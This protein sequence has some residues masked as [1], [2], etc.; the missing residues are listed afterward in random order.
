MREF[1]DPVTVATVAA[2]TLQGAGAIQGGLSAKGQADAEARD[3]RAQATA[4]EVQG[5][6]DLRDEKET[7]RRRSAR[8]RATLAARGV[9][10]TNALALAE[11]QATESGIRQSRISQDARTRSANLRRRASNVKT[12]GRR[13]ATGTFIS[14]GSSALTTALSL[15]SG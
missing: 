4:S 9:E 12:Q 13:E 7:Q 1:R 6:R 11:T 15:R 8:L 10:G 3:L 14:G 2:V 5:A